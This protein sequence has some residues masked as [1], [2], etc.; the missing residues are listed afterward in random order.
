MSF[1]GEAMVLR[2]ET[3]LVATG[4]W[5]LAIRCPTGAARTCVVTRLVKC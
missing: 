4:Q 5:G 2:R 3:V 1:R